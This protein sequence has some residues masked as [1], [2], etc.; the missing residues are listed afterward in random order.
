M[1]RDNL[2][3]VAG[4]LLASTSLTTAANAGQ[5]ALVKTP[6]VALGTAGAFSPVAF[7]TALNLSAQA[8]PNSTAAATVTTGTVNLYFR[9][10]Q[11]IPATFTGII[12]VTG[13]QFATSA[14]SATAIQFESASGTVFGNATAW[15][16]T[17]ICTGAVKGADKILLQG[18]NGA[19]IS[20]ITGGGFIT[21][22]G[23]LITG[24]S[25]TQAGGLATAAT[26][27]SLSADITVGSTVF[28]TTAAAAEITSRDTF[29]V[30][31][32]I[33]TPA[34]IDVAASKGAFT[35]IS[36]SVNSAALGTITI[37]VNPALATDLST[38]VNGAAATASAE[39]KLT[40][41]IT[42]DDATNQFR[43]TGTNTQLTVSVF[44]AGS[45]TFSLPATAFS[46]TDRYT[47]NVDFN[48]TK[49]IDAAAAGTAAVTF[50][51]PG[52]TTQGT[53]NMQAQGA[54]SGLPIAGL[55][56]NG[57][58]I[59]LNG[60]YSSTYAPVYTSVIRIANTG[61]I[62]GA[63]TIAVYDEVTGSL[64]GTAS[65]LA[66]L[67]GGA[68]AQY[69]AAQI[70]AAASVPASTKTYRLVV[71]GGITGY[72]QQLIWNQTSGFFTDLSGRRTSLT[73]NN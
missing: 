19:A 15:T 57:L 65:A 11:E 45:V 60:V 33:G 61:T 7:S 59:S 72:A 31:G 52:T 13:A 28:D 22:N 73:G 9:F 8:F 39:V 2:Y 50:V 48:G 70:E 66:T 71:T 1:K 12:S 67:T 44:Q 10:N 30:S 23:V 53:T 14:T 29:T 63:P 26:S 18:C 3:L 47:V 64:L 24:V 62:A 5:I 20:S 36:T 21:A 46:S 34:S 41:A 35:A 38:L 4:A 58:T 32:V 42:T 49:E 37:S 6:G 68:S 25:F 56:R 16:P 54:T 55:T 27:I 17:T 69:T 40:T 43:L 51:V